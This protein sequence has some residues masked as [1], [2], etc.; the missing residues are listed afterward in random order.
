[1]PSGALEE[2]RSVLPSPLFQLFIQMTPADQFHSYSVRKMLMGCGEENPDLLTAALLHDVGKT[3]LPLHVWERV[4][5]VFGMKFFR[6]QAIAWGR[7]QPTPATRSFVVAVQHAAWGADMV[8]AAGGNPV[9]V[10]IIRRHQDK[11]ESQD[12]LSELLRILQSADNLN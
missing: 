1:M 6:Q 8:K 4:M 5:I 12:E 3:K 11:I 2:V 10:E 7:S 9:V